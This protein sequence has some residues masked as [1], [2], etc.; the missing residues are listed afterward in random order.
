MP[1]ISQL[2]LRASL[3]WLAIGSLIGTL[4]IGT[5]AGFLPGMLL[6]LRGAHGQIMLIGWMLQA[7]I[8]TALWIFPRIG[9]PQAQQDFRLATIGA[10]ALNLGMLLAFLSSLLAL[11]KI[12]ASAL[13]LLAAL[14]E[15][16]AGPLLIAKIWQRTRAGLSIS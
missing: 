4:I 5:K 6:G 8:G 16:V 7:A 10:Y 15:L 13:T 9:S 12:E 1:T 2:L 3:A 14:L 11:G